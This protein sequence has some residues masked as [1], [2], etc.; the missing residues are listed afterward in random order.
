MLVSTMMLFA[1]SY[2]HLLERKEQMMVQNDVPSPP[3]LEVVRPRSRDRIM[4]ESRP[5]PKENNNQAKKT[6]PS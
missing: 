5:I 1:L 3:L 6:M 4:L 2:S